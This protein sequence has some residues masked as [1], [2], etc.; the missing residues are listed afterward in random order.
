MEFKRIYRSLLPSLSGKNSAAERVAVID[1]TIRELG[2]EGELRQLMEY[3]KYHAWGQEKNN[4]KMIEAL[5]EAQQLAPDTN[6]GKRI[7]SVIE[8]LES[9]LKEQAEP[10]EKTNSPGKIEEEEAKPD[11]QPVR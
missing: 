4:Q 9:R 10:A 1:S 11:P 3:Q 5:R 2:L 7:P 6:L 8:F